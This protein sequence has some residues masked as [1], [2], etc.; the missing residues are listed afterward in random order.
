MAAQSYAIRAGSEALPSELQAAEAKPDVAKS[1]RT[2]DHYGEMETP[3]AADEGTA[4]ATVARLATWTQCEWTTQGAV[5]VLATC[6]ARGVF[7]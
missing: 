4:Q 3:L 2:L 6:V 5:A 1:S 7:A